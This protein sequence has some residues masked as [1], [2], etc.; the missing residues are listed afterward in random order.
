MKRFICLLAC[1][2]VILSVR[3]VPAIGASLPEL[4]LSI[5]DIAV[6]AGEE[7]RIWYILDKGGMTVLRLLD[8]NGQSVAELM[9][10]IQTEGAHEFIWDGTDH[11][12]NIP[13]GTYDLE[14]RQSDNETRQL[15]LVLTSPDLPQADTAQQPDAA[16]QADPVPQADTDPQTDIAPQD[17]G[18]PQDDTWFYP[19]PAL[20]SEHVP[21][22]DPKGCYWCTP[23]NIED[24]EAVWAMLTSPMYTLNENQ[25]SQVIIRSEPRDN[26]EGIGVVTG[27]SMGIHVLE[28]RSDGW[29]LIECHSA[30]FFDSKV[31]NWNAFV[32]GYV[33][34]NLIQKKTPDQEYGI[35][36]D[37]LTQQ[38]YLFHEG[39][40]MTTL[41]VST[42]L[43]NQKQPYNE[44]RTGEFMLVS[45]V[46]DFR[47]DAMTCAYAIR[48]D[49]GDLLHEVP[50]V[51]NADGSKN[52]KSTEFNLGSR[53]S[54]GCI[55]VQRL[56]NADG[57]NMLWLYN[58]LTVNAKNG[59]KLVIWEDFQGRTIAYPPDDTPL[60]YNTSGGNYYHAVDNCPSVRSQYL[61]LSA[62]TYGELDSGAY[63]RLTPCSSC[64]PVR[65][66]AEIDAINKEHET[67]SPGMVSDYHKPLK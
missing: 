14:L 16:A 60:Y 35:V 49:G 32:T 67:S 45:K 22:H 20:R 28:N 27:T 5:S 61:P 41:A 47:S 10:E 56:K 19:T 30:S 63:A 9:A 44:T 66:K 40:L 25:K 26:A 11:G 6:E 55:R 1:L 64:Q 59:T 33:R 31:K 34:T 3:T 46:G 7:E 29:S 15:K 12:R 50:H 53:K 21:N 18:A 13:S 52:Y 43:Y 23:M 58:H 42:G 51:K 54:H 2:A 37:K 38:L 8:S 62:F 57:I 17:D 36:I 48:F 65:R 39:H 24:E 4:S